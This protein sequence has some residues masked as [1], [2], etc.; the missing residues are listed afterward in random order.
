MGPG[1]LCALP[2]SHRGGVV[3]VLP[4]LLMAQPFPM[5]ICDSVVPI[6]RVNKSF[7][8]QTHRPCL[9]YILVSTPPACVVHPLTVPL[10]QGS[11]VRHVVFTSAPHL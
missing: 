2:C 7:L 10:Q 3:S 8:S 4:H 11:G 5:S 6:S 9:L 1:A